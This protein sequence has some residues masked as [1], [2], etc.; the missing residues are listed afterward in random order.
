MP[1]VLVFGAGAAGD[2]AN[3]AGRR[4]P[5]S[6][7]RCVPSRLVCASSEKLNPRPGRSGGVSRHGIAASVDVAHPPTRLIA[8]LVLHHG[9]LVWSIAPARLV[10]EVLRTRTVLN[11]G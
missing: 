7:M 5:A 3:P 9:T 2:R 1:A 6:Q 11:R 10:G 4:D 8:W